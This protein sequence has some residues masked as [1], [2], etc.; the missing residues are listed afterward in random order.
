MI[1]AI[2]LAWAVSGYRRAA[3]ER[4]DLSVHARADSDAAATDRPSSSG[5]QTPPPRRELGASAKEQAKPDAPPGALIRGRCL[6]AR[7]APVDA[8]VELV[9]DAGSASG[10]VERSTVPDASGR[11]EL[12]APRGMRRAV[13]RFRAPR[14]VPVES[15]AYPV[16]DGQVL[17]VGDVRLVLGVRLRGTVTDERGRPVAGVHVTLSRPLDQSRDAR[18]S[19][20]VRPLDGHS[21]GDGVLELGV[22]LAGWYHVEVTGRLLRSRKT[23]EILPGLAFQDLSIVVTSRAR[24]LSISGKVVDR[25]G[26]PVANATVEAIEARSVQFRTTTDAAGRF[27]VLRTREGSGRDTRVGGCA[28]GHEATYL[29][30]RVP[31]GTHD[32]LLRL[33]DLTRLELSVVRAGTQRAVERFG[34]RLNRI[35]GSSLVPVAFGARLPLRSASVHPGGRLELPLHRARYELRVEPLDDPAAASAFQ[36]V[37][38]TDR[39][40]TKLRVEVPATTERVLQLQ[41]RSGEPI[42]GCRVVLC[43]PL[44]KQ[45]SVHTRIVE[46]R[47]WGR[48]RLPDRALVV[49][50]GTTDDA[51]QVTLRGPRDER[52]ALRIRGPGCVKAMIP[53]PRLEGDGPLVQICNLGARIRLRLGPESA[54]RA[55]AGL[56]TPNEPVP[57]LELHRVAGSQAAVSAEFRVGKEGGTTISFHVPPGKWRPELHHA[58]GVHGWPAVHATEGSTTDCQLDLTPLRPITIEGTLLRRG[59]PVPYAHVGVEF[60]SRRSIPG[61]FYWQRFPTTTDGAGRFRFRGLPG[62]YNVVARD[63]RAGNRRKLAQPSDIRIGPDETFR[64]HFDVET[65]TT[66]IRIVDVAGKPVAGVSGIRVYR[67]GSQSLVTTLG[68]T[69]KDGRI[70]L[71]NFETGSFELIVMPK[72]LGSVN[73]QIR[74]AMKTKSTTAL[75][76]LRIKLGRIVVS[77]GHATVHTLVLRESYFH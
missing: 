6:D 56:T 68:P 61:S 65:S 13:L 34:L 1:V 15:R 18:R 25:D 66:T 44:R 48:F 22:A 16:V 75:N 33:R 52:L 51:G 72:R 28:T 73:S 35:D 71:P 77:T 63:S 8:S 41:T 2:V 32:L 64:S 49:D 9:A 46:A 29:P 31:W 45:T 30:D 76:A 53:I 50:S 24:T 70:V 21:A 11:F 40:K 37:T 54:L 36:I 27:A 57:T 62:R 7:D 39:P 42:A 47:D 20:H 5:R 26:R 43:L 17:D 59:T 14:R 3:A 60:W 58:R 23:V 12:R 38:I 19:L 67:T 10:G 4:T 55:L 69:D 74:F